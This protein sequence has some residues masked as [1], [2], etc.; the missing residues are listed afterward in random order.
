MTKLANRARSTGVAPDEINA[1]SPSETGVTQTPGGNP[2]FRE[3]D[4]RARSIGI[5]AAVVLLHVGVGYALATAKGPVPP[6]E[7]APPLEATIIDETPVVAAAEPPPPTPQPEP[8]PPE[9]TPPPPPD[10]T[11]PPPD[12]APAPEPPPPPPQPEKPPEKPPEKHQEKPRHEPVKHEKPAKP[13]AAEPHPA[14][15]KAAVATAPSIDRSQSCPT[16]QYPREAQDAGATGV[17]KLLFVIDENGHVVESRVT[18]GSGYTSLDQAAL[19]ALSRCKFNPAIAN[20][21]RQR[22][23]LSLSYRWQLDN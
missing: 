7:I 21:Q 9:V 23:S 16:P 20:G 14:P 11:P 19:R 18:S 2:D 8:P 15:A 17:T 3:N 4:L 5:F 6:I 12:P 10:P 1:G 13:H 22:A